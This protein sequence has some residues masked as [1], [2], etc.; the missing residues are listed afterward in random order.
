MFAEAADIDRGEVRETLNRFWGISTSSM[1]YEPVGFGSHHYVAVDPDGS[2]WFLTVND[3]RAK[4]WIAS[5]PS[6][7]FDALER[8]FRTAVE[9]RDGGLEFVLAPSPHRDGGVL[10]RVGDHYSLAVFAFLDARPS[11]FDQKLDDDQRRALLTALGRLHSSS[12]VPVDGP[13][14][15]DLQIPSRARLMRSL[16]ELDRPWTGGL[17]SELARDLVAGATDGLR[18]RLATYDALAEDVR[19]AD[20]PWVVTHGEPHPG[21]L[22]WTDDSFVLIDWDT[23]AIGPPERDLW[24]VE[25]EDGDDLDAYVSAGGATGVRASAIE[26]YELWWSLA[27][28]AL[29]VDVLRSSHQN[30]ANT[31]TAL[32]GL[33][34]YL[35]S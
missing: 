16:E 10:A 29:Y 21:N 34:K 32:S 24:M 23:V 14:R 2:R 28:V 31:R 6:G 15:D 17:F 8:A 11:N 4:G 26:L 5:E 9:L 1:S 20:T 22:M 18:K 3:L 13:R 19:S 12:L 30:D 25:I 7:N 35:P 33:R 27:E